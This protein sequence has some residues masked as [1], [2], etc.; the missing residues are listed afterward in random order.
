MARPR[1]LTARCV[2]SSWAGVA[3]ALL[4]FALLAGT[5]E[6]RPKLAGGCFSVAGQ[7]VRF[8]AAALGKYLFYTADGKYLSGAELTPVDTPGPD[9]IHAVPDKPRPKRATGCAVFPNAD[10]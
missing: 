3:S 9:A 4:L 10:T 7:P 2:R 8:Q 6:A 5:A 1:P